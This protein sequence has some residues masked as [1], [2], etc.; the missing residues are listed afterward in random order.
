MNLTVC[1]FSPTVPSSICELN[2][3]IWHRIEKDLYLYTSKQRAWLYV[4][5]ANEEKLITEDLLIMN[6]RVDELNPSSDHSWENQSDE[7]WMLRSKFSDKIDQTVTEMNVLFNVNVIDSRSQWIFM[8]S[9]LQFNIQSKISIARLSVLRGKIKFRSNAWTTLKVKI[10]N[11]F[12][13]VQIFDTH[14]I[15]DVEVCKNIIDVHENYLSKS[16]TDSFTIQ[17]IEKILNV[18]KTD[19]MILVED[20]LHH[21]IFDNQFVF[22]KMIVFIIERLISFTAVFDNHNNKNIHALSR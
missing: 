12:K 14:M 22:F 3:R 7:I 2:P 17:F 11:K 10:N 4:A 21:D 5:L 13:I 19:F 8:R 15:T 9:S 6:I 16:E 20:Q 1:I 18:E